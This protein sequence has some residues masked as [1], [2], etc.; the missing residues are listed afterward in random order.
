MTNFMCPE[1]RLCSEAELRREEE[2][3]WPEEEP[4]S[5]ERG[6]AVAAGLH[7]AEKI[8]SKKRGNKKIDHIRYRRLNGHI[9][10][11]YSWVVKSCFAI[12]L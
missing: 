5:V 4:R 2:W 1:M 10:V 7:E 11:S 3:V 9:I 6:Q 8:R 12:A